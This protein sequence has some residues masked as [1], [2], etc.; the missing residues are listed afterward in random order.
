[1][2]S[3]RFCHRLHLTEEVLQWFGVQ[4]AFVAHP[5]ISKVPSFTDMHPHNLYQWVADFHRLSGFQPLPPRVSRF[6]RGLRSSLHHAKNK[7][8]TPIK[9]FLR[10]LSRSPSLLA[11]RQL[12]FFSHS[13][14]L[15]STI[16]HPCVQ[17]FSSPPALQNEAWG[18]TGPCTKQRR[19][20]SV[21][22]LI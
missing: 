16:Q 18:S 11:E 14:L 5:C 12:C 19:R 21:S 1:M 20:R 15:S 10:L 17:S 7:L 6:W 8:V 4:S 2:R 22:N 9:Q 13:D 3:S